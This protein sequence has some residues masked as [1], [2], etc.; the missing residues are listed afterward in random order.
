GSPNSSPSR[1]PARSSL[2][3]LAR[4]GSG[5]LEQVEGRHLL[6][7][8]DA[9]RAPGDASPAADA[10]GGAELL[11]PGAQLVG[12]PLAVAGLA[13]GP[14]AAAVQ[15][16]EVEVEA[17]VPAAPPLGVVAGEVADVLG[18]GAEAGRADHGAVAA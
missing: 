9:G 1:S 3:L 12:D 14:H 13:T 7:D 11:V 5:R 16:G 8:V 17:R 2:R 15:V 18:G 4:L 10:A 6:G